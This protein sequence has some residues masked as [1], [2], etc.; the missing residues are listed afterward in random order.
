MILDDSK[1]KYFNLFHPHHLYLKSYKIYLLVMQCIL[2]VQTSREEV[3]CEINLFQTNCLHQQ[4]QH[5]EGQSMHLRDYG[6]MN[7]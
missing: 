5:V 3:H 6:F 2:R 4:F 7:H 1:V